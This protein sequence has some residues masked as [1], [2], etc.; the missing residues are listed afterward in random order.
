MIPA[1]HERRFNR[2]SEITE[3][4]HIVILKTSQELG[5][6]ALSSQE[7]KGTNDLVGLLVDAI[8]DV[9][10]ADSSLTESPPANLLDTD[11][12]FLSGVLKT[13]VGLLVLLNLQEVLST[14]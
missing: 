2:A 1:K 11:E 7:F 14:T 6:A 5:S 4:S 13:E 9:V 10:E 3:K 12:R 8:G